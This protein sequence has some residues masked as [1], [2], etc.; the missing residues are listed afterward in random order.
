M[1]RRGLEFL[2]LRELDAVILELDAGKGE[3]EPNWL[4]HA[5]DIEVGELDLGRHF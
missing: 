3:G 5:F 1:R 2:P 4:G